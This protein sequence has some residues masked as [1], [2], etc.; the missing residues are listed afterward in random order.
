ME[1]TL[2]K[3]IN[4]KS[5]SEVLRIASKM[6]TGEKISYEEINLIAEFNPIFTA[7]LRN[8]KINL[9][10]LRALC[11]KKGGISIKI[12]FFVPIDAY[13]FII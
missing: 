12:K 7:T 13:G 9:N 1:N 11:Y 8:N 6:Y 3:K 10:K 5:Y 2:N 4:H